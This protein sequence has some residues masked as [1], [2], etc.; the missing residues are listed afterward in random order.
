[1]RLNVGTFEWFD[2][3]IP[4]TVFFLVASRSTWGLNSLTRDQTRIPCF[5]R[6]SLNY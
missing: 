4:S 6:Q 2:F 5:E 3:V 1:M